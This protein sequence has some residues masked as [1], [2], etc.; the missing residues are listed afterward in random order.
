MTTITAPGLGITLRV[1]LLD[2]INCLVKFATD[3][4]A[5]GDVDALADYRSRA[6]GMPYA[7]PTVEHFVPLFLTL[8]AADGPDSPVETTVEGYQFGLAKRSFQVA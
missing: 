8:G 4:T 1:E 2:Y 5:T 7:H 3:K 6:P